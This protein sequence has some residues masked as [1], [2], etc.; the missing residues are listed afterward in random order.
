MK[1][2]TSPAETPLQRALAFLR[3]VKICCSLNLDRLSNPPDNTVQ[4]VL[5]GSDFLSGRGAYGTA[6]AVTPSRLADRIAPLV[7]VAIVAGTPVLSVYVGPI[8]SGDQEARS[9]TRQASGNGLTRL[10]AA[11]EDT[12]APN[13]DTNESTGP[14]VVTT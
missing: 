10:D 11:G 1:R 6:R 9:A 13:R 4:P 2:V 8:C 12:S 5:F 7:S 3:I 14:C